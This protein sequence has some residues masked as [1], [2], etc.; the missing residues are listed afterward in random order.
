MKHVPL[1][2]E[3]EQSC[4]RSHDLKPGFNVATEVQFKTISSWTR[5]SECVW[6]GNRVSLVKVAVWLLY[7]LEYLKGSWIFL[8]LGFFSVIFWFYCAADVNSFFFPGCVWL[9]VHSKRRKCPGSRGLVGI[10]TSLASSICCWYSLFSGTMCRPLLAW[11]D[12][13]DV[14]EEPGLL[15]WPH[16]TSNG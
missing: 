10:L 7:S 5:Q 1:G 3:N 2:L 8:R 16:G 6:G 13:P 11:P 15:L 9:K 12:F 14:G 4:R